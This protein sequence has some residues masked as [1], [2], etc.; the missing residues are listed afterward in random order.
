LKKGKSLTYQ[1]E[2]LELLNKRFK[3]YDEIK[4]TYFVAEVNGF[5][6][7]KLIKIYR[8][9]ESF[10]LQKK[11]LIEISAESLKDK[12]VTNVKILDPKDQKK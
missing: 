3:R 9:W 11:F 2:Q 10:C 12:I 6:Y 4:D 8:C 7:N 1:H 5:S